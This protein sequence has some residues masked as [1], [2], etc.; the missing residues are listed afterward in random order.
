MKRRDLV[1]KLERAGFRFVR[2]GGGHDIYRRGPD[3]E[4]VPMHKEINERL[5]KGILKKWGIQ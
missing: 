4:Q 5:A 1:K 2:H 3:E